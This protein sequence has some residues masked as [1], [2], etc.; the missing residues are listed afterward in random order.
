MKTY[1]VKVYDDC[2]FSVIVGKYTSQKKARDRV[3]AL[4]GGIPRLVVSYYRTDNECWWELG[5]ERGDFGEVS[6]LTEG[7]EVRL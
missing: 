4:L 3:R 7:Y 5:N 6:I 2:G 1:F